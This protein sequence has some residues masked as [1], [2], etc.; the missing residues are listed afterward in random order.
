MAKSGWIKGSST[1]L[2]PTKGLSQPAT[3]W[4]SIE[5]LHGSDGGAWLRLKS[6]TVSSGGG[7]VV[8]VRL[9]AV[10]CVRQKSRVGRRAVAAISPQENS[11]G[12]AQPSL[13]AAR[14]KELGDDPPSSGSRSLVAGLPHV[15]SCGCVVLSWFPKSPGGAVYLPACLLILGFFLRLHI[16]L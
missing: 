11:R 5:V 12:C 13:V 8:A 9:A 10:L 1:V 14:G 6:K 2:E 7:E 3:I 16:L 15:S 4:R